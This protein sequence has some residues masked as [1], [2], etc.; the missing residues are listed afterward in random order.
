[1]IDVT[2]T[3][4]DVTGTDVEIYSNLSRRY[5]NWC[6]NLD[7]SYSSFWNPV[8]LTAPNLPPWTNALCEY[9]Q[10]NL[11]KWNELCECDQTN[12]PPRPCNRKTFGKVNR[13]FTKF[14]LKN[15]HQSEPVQPNTNIQSINHFAKE[16]IFLPFL[17]VN[18]ITNRS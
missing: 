9:D 1:M 5:R 15:H 18:P 12:W 13:S 16:K 11:N 2:G 7:A 6:W 4:L 14:H 8:T 3:Y 10:T 17:F